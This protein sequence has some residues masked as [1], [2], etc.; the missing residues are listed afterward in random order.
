MIART[1]SLVARTSLTSNCNRYIRIPESYILG[2]MS[3]A[4]VVCIQETNVEAM[5]GEFD[6]IYIL[7]SS[8]CRTY[9]SVVS[10]VI[11]MSFNLNC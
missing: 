9:S 4:C 10:L 5:E 3:A 1:Q 7:V 6:F 2:S 11:R 8:V